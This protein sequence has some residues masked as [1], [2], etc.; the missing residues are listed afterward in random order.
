MQRA[1]WSVYSCLDDTIMGW[2]G[3]EPALLHLFTW[4]RSLSKSFID[5][6]VSFA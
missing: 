1:L 3:G 4:E 5:V 2:E 6:V